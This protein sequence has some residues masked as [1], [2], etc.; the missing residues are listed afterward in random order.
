[1]RSM[2]DERVIFSIL[3]LGG[4]VPKTERIKLLQAP[5]EYGKFWLPLYLDYKDITGTTHDLIKELIQDEYSKMPFSGHDDMMDCMARIM[6]DKMCLVF[7]NV[8]IKEEVK[9]KNFDWLRM[10]G[11]TGSNVDWSAR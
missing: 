5:F 1:M 6:D 3:D 9:H 4:N 10:V 7:P 11:Q 2:V 8:G